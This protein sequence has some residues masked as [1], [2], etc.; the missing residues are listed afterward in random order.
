M[1]KPF[2]DRLREIKEELQKDSNEKMIFLLNPK[3]TKILEAIIAWQSMRIKISPSLLVEDTATL[4]DL[5]EMMDDN[6]DLQNFSVTLGCRASDAL[7]RLRQLKNLSL[8]FPDGSV[9]ST[10]LVLIKIY[11]KK[12]LSKIQIVEKKEKDDKDEE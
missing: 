8:I 12:Q 4:E 11:I 3:E 6:I 9:N 7:T 2:A 1:M 10:A 5:W